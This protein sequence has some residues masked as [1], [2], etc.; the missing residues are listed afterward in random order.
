[1]AIRQDLRRA[2]LPYSRVTLFNRPKC[3]RTSS[4]T[5][6][7]NRTRSAPASESTTSSCRTTRSLIFKS[8]VALIAFTPPSIPPSPPGRSPC[9]PS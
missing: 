7:H 1:M 3:R 6:T 4:L 2:A 9:I 5:G 8:S